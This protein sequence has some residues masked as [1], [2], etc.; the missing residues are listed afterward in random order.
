[1]SDNYYQR[2]LDALPAGESPQFRTYLEEKIAGKAS[3]PE[4]QPSPEPDAE[5]DEARNVSKAEPV[6]EPKTEPKP[7]KTKKRIGLREVVRMTRRR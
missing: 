4:P 5:L 6:Q 2:L 1:M 7:K 3:T